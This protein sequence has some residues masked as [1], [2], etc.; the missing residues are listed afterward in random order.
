MTT[1]FPHF[2]LKTELYIYTIG[3]TYRK[4]HMRCIQLLILHFILVVLQC[5]KLFVF[6]NVSFAGDDRSSC[7][8]F[9]YRNT[10]QPHICFPL[11]KACK[12]Q[13]RSSSHNSLKTTGTITAGDKRRARRQPETTR[14]C[15][16]TLLAS[17]QS[18]YLDNMFT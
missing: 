9:L 10:L 6:Q 3:S 13:T 15:F 12:A 16:S 17:R 18:L 7:S 4:Q 2:C 11:A 14:D 5:I 8:L 1:E